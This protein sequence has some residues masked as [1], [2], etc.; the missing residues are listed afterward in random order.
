M[1]GIKERMDNDYRI[2]ENENGKYVKYNPETR[3]KAFFS[4]LV[5]NEIA[6]AENG[7]TELKSVEELA[8]IYGATVYKFRHLQKINKFFL[9]AFVHELDRKIGITNVNDRNFNKLALLVLADQQDDYSATNIYD[10]EELKKM[11]AP[12]NSK[13]FAE[14]KVL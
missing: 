6:K 10:V 9:H 2:Y 3:S 5:K 7:M 14:Q 8:N 11:Y 12:L 1:I 4:L 13:I